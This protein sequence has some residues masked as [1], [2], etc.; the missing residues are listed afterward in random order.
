MKI[1]SAIYFSKLSGLAFWPYAIRLS[2][3][4]SA[5]KLFHRF[6][7]MGYA[8]EFYQNVDAVNITKVSDQN[9]S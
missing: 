5:P 6:R 7:S 4:Y 2:K 1:P 3:C 9:S 8:T